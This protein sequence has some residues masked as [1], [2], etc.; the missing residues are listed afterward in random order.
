MWYPRGKIPN[1]REIFLV[2]LLSLSINR[3]NDQ[4]FSLLRPI[5]PKLTGFGSYRIGN[6]RIERSPEFDI[7][8]G[9]CVQNYHHECAKIN[10]NRHLS[11]ASSP[12]SQVTVEPTDPD[13]TAKLPFFQ[14]TLP[15]LE[16][17][18]PKLP[19]GRFAF[20][21]LGCSTANCPLA[22]SYTHKHSDKGNHIGHDSSDGQS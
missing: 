10:R 16:S 19:Q 20:H 17:R 11:T 18:K 14:I 1:D 12:D 13:R 5:I 2:N 15:Y 22:I 21:R 7:S 4:E 3:L 8:F 9:V 6:R